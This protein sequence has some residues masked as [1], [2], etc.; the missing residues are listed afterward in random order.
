M[1]KQKNK[2]SDIKYEQIIANKACVCLSKIDSITN[3]QDAITKC[4]IEAKNKVHEEDAKN[5]YGRDYTVEGIRKIHKDVTEL[6]IANCTI[7]SIK[8]YT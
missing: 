8:N 4:I 6:L 5:F 2:K 7:I 3:S 1:G